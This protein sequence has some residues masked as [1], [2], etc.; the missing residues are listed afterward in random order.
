MSRLSVQVFSC[1]S[2]FRRACGTTYVG[3]QPLFSTSYKKAMEMVNEGRAEIISGRRE[4]RLKIRL[5]ALHRLPHR[6]PAAMTAHEM[7][8]H[9]LSEIG[10]KGISKKVREELEE[11]I[12]AWEPERKK[13]CRNPK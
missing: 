7:E 10:L 13:L 3:D 2:S 12:N 9:A 11:K 4:H 1:Q 6:S 5:V 8:I